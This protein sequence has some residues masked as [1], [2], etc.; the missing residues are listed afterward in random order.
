MSTCYTCGVERRPAAEPFSDGANAGGNAECLARLAEARF[1]AVS[2]VV[3]QDAKERS[4]GLL[5]AW[6]YIRLRC[7]E[8]DDDEEEAEIK[9]VQQNV[10]K[11]S[12]QLRMSSQVEIGFQIT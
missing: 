12:A 6:V 1:W 4:D 3:N 2:L 9:V 7:E 11:C 5:L 8:D 10:E